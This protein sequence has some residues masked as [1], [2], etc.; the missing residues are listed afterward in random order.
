MINSH[1]NT[2]SS[3]VKSN[4]T[5]YR[6]ILSTSYPFALPPV[7]NAPPPFVAMLRIIPLM[8]SDNPNNIVPAHTQANAPMLSLLLLA[9][10]EFTI[11][12]NAIITIL[13]NTKIPPYWHC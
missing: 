9:L 7:I 1:R 4:G 13:T 2:F 3:C 12:F 10:F 8:I 11:I 6:C 5:L